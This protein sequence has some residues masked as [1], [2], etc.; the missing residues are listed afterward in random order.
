MLSLS[1]IKYLLTRARFVVSIIMMISKAIINK[2]ISNATA[3][4]YEALQSKP[5]SEE[6]PLP[7]TRTDREVTASLFSAHSKPQF[8]QR[9]L[10]AIPLAMKRNPKSEENWFYLRGAAIQNVRM[11]KGKNNKDWGNQRNQRQGSDNFYQRFQL[12]DRFRNSF[13]PTTDRGKECHD[14]SHSQYV[15]IKARCI[16]SGRN[17]TFPWCIEFIYFRPSCETPDVIDY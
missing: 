15:N 10:N 16:I 2:M 9:C 11:F 7:I 8:V 5:R 12:S 3:E 1:L 17:G 13:Q 6:K 4:C 14:N